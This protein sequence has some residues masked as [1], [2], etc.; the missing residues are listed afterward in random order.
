MVP[1]WSRRPKKV[2]IFAKVRSFQLAIRD[3]EVILGPKKNSI[4]YLFV[5]AI[6]LFKKM[7]SNNKFNQSI[8]LLLPR[9]STLSPDSP[10]KGTSQMP[11]VEN[12][13][14]YDGFVLVCPATLQI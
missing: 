14:C 6:I 12:I 9:I 10:V 13:V 3:F 4:A 8:G 1:S 7:K 11:L 5:S 2:Q